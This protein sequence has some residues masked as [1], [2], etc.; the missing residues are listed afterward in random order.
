MRGKKELTLKSADLKG[1][2]S[3]LTL[4]RDTTRVAITLILS[5]TV[6]FYPIL[7]CLSLD[8]DS[9]SAAAR[10]KRGAHSI[11]K[12]RQSERKNLMEKRG[13]PVQ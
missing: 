12:C 1:P 13:L 2:E 8:L 10:E 11:G 3:A 5:T 7:F 6:I 9:L 4:Q